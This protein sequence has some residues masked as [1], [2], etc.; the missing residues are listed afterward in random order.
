M[1]VRG[2]P[3]SRSLLPR[4]PNSSSHMTSDPNDEFSEAAVLEWISLADFYVWPHI[5][6]VFTVADCMYTT[7]SRDTNNEFATTL[8]A[9]L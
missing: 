2:A 3:S 8:N 9:R 6:Q 4:H 1:S 7:R 5:T